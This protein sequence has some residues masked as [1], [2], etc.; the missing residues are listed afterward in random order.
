[1][2]GDAATKA[3]RKAVLSQLMMLGVVEKYVAAVLATGEKESHCRRPLSRCSSPMKTICTY[4]PAHDDVEEDQLH[5][6]EPS[7]L[8]DLV[9]DWLLRGRRII[10]LSSGLPRRLRILGFV[11]VCECGLNATLALVRV[12]SISICHFCPF[13]GG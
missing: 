7:D 6:A 4:V 11:C 10:Y 3:K 9:Y 8:V 12:Y 2:G 13:I 5:Q 1:M